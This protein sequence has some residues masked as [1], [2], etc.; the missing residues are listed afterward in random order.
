MQVEVERPLEALSLSRKPRCRKPNL[1][2][3]FFANGGSPSR[4]STITL[5]IHLSIDHGCSRIVDPVRGGA[6]RPDVCSVITV[7]V[8]G[9]CN[10]HPWLLAFGD[11]PDAWN[12]LLPCS[13]FDVSLGIA[14]KGQVG[15]EEL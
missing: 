6:T 9:K 10:A 12:I 11:C 15:L 4:S 8:N 13:L 7:I 2:I 14:S 1:G 5:C 3:G